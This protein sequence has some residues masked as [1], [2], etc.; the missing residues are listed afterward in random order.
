MRPRVS[1]RVFREWGAFP[2]PAQEG[3][4][5]GIKEEVR[6]GRWGWQVK[7]LSPAG[8]EEAGRLRSHGVRRVPTVEVGAGW[9]SGMGGDLALRLITPVPVR[10]LSPPSGR[11][12]RGD[13]NFPGRLGNWGGGLPAARR[14]RSLSPLS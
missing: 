5:V 2:G 1:N 6:K 9:R 14:S 10:V 12:D 3:M 4:E 13:Q 11:N 7:G 8:D